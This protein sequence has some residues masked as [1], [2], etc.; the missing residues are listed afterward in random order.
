MIEIEMIPI[1]SGVVGVF[2]NVLQCVS[3]TTFIEYI[4]STSSVTVSVAIVTVTGNHSHLRPP[5]FTATLLPDSCQV[6]VC[7]LYS[8]LGFV[9]FFT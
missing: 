2:I 8:L 5:S 7:T 9:A 6:V 3:Y 1:T 4:I